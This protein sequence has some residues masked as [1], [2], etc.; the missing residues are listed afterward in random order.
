MTESER[1]RLAAELLVIRASGTLSDDQ[2]RYPRWELPNPELRRLLREGVGGVILL[3]GSAAELSLRTRELQAWADQ[4]L[5]LCADVEEGVGQR[6]EGASWLAPPLSLGRLHGREPQRAEELAERY[7]RCIGREARAVGLNWVLAPVVDVNNNPANPVINVRAWGEDPATVST[8]ATAFLRGAAAEGVLC[9]AK[10]FPG[11]GDTDQDS[12]LE[13]PRLS[14]DRPRLDAVELP[15]FRA[16]ISAG[17]PAV[18]TA[19]LLLPALDQERPATLSAAVLTDLLRLDLGF[20]GLVV[21]DALVME[22]ITAHWPAGEAAVL[23][24]EAGADLVLMPADADAAIEAISAAL[25]SGRLPLERLEASRQRRRQALAQLPNHPVERDDANPLGWL[26]NG[27]QACDRTLAVELIE[28]GLERQGVVQPLEGVRVLLR[29]DGGPGSVLL[30]PTAPALSRPAARGWPLTVLDG[31]SPTPWS[32][33]P[34]EPL[35]LERLGAERLLLLLFIRGNPFRG[36]MASCEPWAAVIEQLQRAGRLAALG[37]LGSPYVWDEL[38]PL[39]DPGVAAVYSPAQTPLA[40]Q[41]VLE[42]LESPAR[43]QPATS[44]SS[45]SAFTD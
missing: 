27:P 31:V 20:S 35:A 18:M 19:H 28:T 32:G 16:L 13:L 3:G 29:I 38:R 41:L 43:P 14:H 7:G 44:R 37:V 25:E 23:A 2:R 36:S 42:A 1:R 11:H 21:T 5:L 10:H 45:A 34:A 8:L 6:F 15:P 22:G 26:S 24:L 33:D 12:H 17:V 40:Q 9:C 30:P 39:L 4:P